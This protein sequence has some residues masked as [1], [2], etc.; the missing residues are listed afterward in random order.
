MNDQMSLREIGER[1]AP[2][3]REYREHLHRNPELRWEENNSLAFVEETL[4]SF[5]QDSVLPAERVIIQSCLTGG[6]ILDIIFPDTTTW[7]GCRADIDALPIHEETGLPFT[8]RFPGKMHACGHDL[9]S[10]W[11]LA[12]AKAVLEG[13]VQP[14]HN[15]RF[16]WQRAEE[17]PITESGGA[18]LVREGLCTGIDHFVGLHVLAT[19]ERGKFLSR[20][21][22]ML[23]NSDRLQITIKCRGGHI[24]FPSRGS[25]AID[26]ATDIHIALRGLAARYFSPNEP[27]AFAPCVTNSGTASNVRPSECVIWYGNRHYLEESGRQRWEGA[28]ERTVRAVVAQYPDA[29]V[30]IDFV[31]GHPALVNDAE[32]VRFVNKALHN[33]GLATGVTEQIAGGE[34]FAHIIKA[35]QA[36][37]FWYLGA[38]QD[39]L[40]DDSPDHHEPK[41]NP[42]DVYEEAITFWLSLMTMEGLPNRA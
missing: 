4:R 13:A 15:L 25:N 29:S 6:L 42:A 18:R 36:G 37:S 35:A 38:A 17:N 7:L 10:G 8:S 33:N 2:I 41:F 30:S 31:H 1:Y 20:E 27:R 11:L 39:E 28:I 32:S 5:R 3:S 22:T 24:A 12:A 19:G 9:H 34:D 23:A 26:I 21:G 40:G 14:K 16:V